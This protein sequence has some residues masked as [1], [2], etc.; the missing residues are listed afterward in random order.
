[1]KPCIKDVELSLKILNTSL[2]K[3]YEEDE[4]DKALMDVMGVGIN[5]VSGLYSITRY[6][7]DNGLYQKWQIIGLEVEMERFLY[8][9]NKENW[10][11]VEDREDSFIALINYVYTMCCRYCEIHQAINGKIIVNN[12]VIDFNSNQ[13]HE[14]NNQNLVSG[15]RKLPKE[16]DNPK[17]KEVLQRGIKANLLDENYQLLEGVTQGQAYLFALYASQELRIYKQWKVFGI[18]LWGI[19]NLGKVKLESARDERL[20]V[21]RNLFSE[22]IIKDAMMK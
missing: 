4:I 5:V 18:S 11:C 10:L 13:K 17:A 16:L 2:V 19:K 7:E 9:V 12:K 6:M 20:D 22:K 3:E 14:D 21:V 15:S 1:M 8:I